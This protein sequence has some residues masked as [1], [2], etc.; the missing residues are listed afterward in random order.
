MILYGIF[1]MQS[2]QEF[3]SSKITGY[4]S[5][6]INTKVSLKGIDISIFDHII[7]EKLYIE[8][9]RQDTL[10]YVDYLGVSID[11]LDIS[12]ELVEIGKIS[13]KKL[14]F[15]LK[16]DTAS[17]MNLQF[18]IDAFTDST[19]VD[20]T[21]TA[22]EFNWKIKCRKINI[23]N[24]SFSYF[25]SDTASHIS[26]MNYSDI[27]LSPIN[28]Y[29]SDFSF[30]KNIIKLKLDSLNLSDKSGL[31]LKKLN[32]EILYSDT[33]I[34]LSNG[35]LITPYSN[36]YFKN[37]SLHYASTDDFGDFLNKVKLNVQISDST[38]LSMKDGVFF[39][40][41][42]S[43]I[44][45]DIKLAANLF[46]VVNDLNTKLLRIKYG[47]NTKL[48]TRFTIKGLP[49]IDKT[50]FKVK[51]D[52]LTAS[53]DDLNSV[54]S[55]DN[56]AKPMV[57]LPASMKS[58]GKIYY[59]GIIKGRADNLKS[60]GRLITDIGNI[61]AML[62]LVQHKNGTMNING[63]L[64]GKQLAISDIIENKSIGK[65]DIK[66]TLNINITKSGDIEGVS[67]G[68]ANNIELLGYKYNHIDFKAILAKNEY[69]G[70]VKI[71][72]PS[73]KASLSGNYSTKDTVPIISFDTRIDKFHPYKLNLYSD[74]FFTAKLK[75]DGKIRG[76]DPDKLTANL[77]CR[78]GEIKNKQGSITNKDIKI[79]SKYTE[80]DSTHV[81]NLISD[82]ID[83]NLKGRLKLSTIA[84]SSQQYLYGIM[85]SLADT[86]VTLVENKDSLYAAL[87][88]DN[89]FDFKI[90][91][92]DLSG[93]DTM[94]MSGIKIAEGTGLSGKFNL[95]PN[96]LNLQGYCPSINVSGTKVEEIIINGANPDNKIDVYTSIGKIYL[97]ES[98]AINNSLI[99]SQ[100]IDDKAKLKLVWNS[101]LDSL[102]YNGDFS[103]TAFLEKRDTIAPLI[104]LQLDSSTF[105]FENNQ[106]I[107]RSNEMSID[108][109]RIDLG[110]ILARSSNQETIDVSGIISKS[111][112]DTLK[113]LLDKIKLSSFNN[114]VENLGI[115][116]HGTAYGKSEI[117]GVL[118]NLRVNSVDSIVGL[119]IDDYEVGDVRMRAKWDNKHSL[120]NLY[121]ETQL[122]STKNMI[123][124]GAYNVEKDSL[125]MN[126]TVTRFPFNTISPF[127]A[128]YMSKI[129]GKI[130][131]NL[132][133]EGSSKKPEI[134]AGLK[135]IRAGFKVNYLNTTYTF[136]DS[137]FI[138]K[139]MI[140]L[141]RMKINAGRN[142]FAWLSGKL[143]HKNFEN[144]KLNLSVEPHNFLFLDT[145]ETDSSLF[146][147][148]VYASGRINVNGDPDNMDVD[149]KLK[150]ERGTRFFLPLTSSSEVSEN[151]Y[152][153]FVKRDSSR[154]E[155][156]VEQKVDLSGININCQLQA[157]SDAEMQIIM[158]ETVGDVIKVR[159]MGNLDLQVNK[160]GDISL[161]GTYTVTKGD[162]LFT[163][164]NLVNK[165]FIVDRGSTIR[166]YGNPY[167]A[168]MN[169]TALYKIRKVPLYDLMQD[170]AFKERK[171][172]VECKLGMKGYLSN[173]RISFGLNVLDADEIV[174]SS[175]H[176]LDQNDLNQ[177]ILSLLLLG[178]FQ[179]L[180]GLRSDDA[181]SGSDA[182]SNNAI[183]MLSN[184]LTNWLSKISDDFDIGINY[185]K[186]GEMSSDEVEMAL[187]TQ[188][189]NDRVSINT[190]V[191][192]SGSGNT[193]VSETEK[194][195]ANKI[196]GD[197]EIEV[198]LNKKGSLRAKVFNRTN[199]RNAESS[200]KSLYTQGVGIFFRKEFRTVGE[201][202]TD[203][204]KTVTFQNVKKKKKLKKKKRSERRKNRKNRKNK[205][206]TQNKDIEKEERG[207]EL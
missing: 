75:M 195:S 180:P 172:N 34:D 108:T 69:K 6:K 70:N 144:I 184:Q 82:I 63:N 103:L 136:T 67:T 192:V 88:R 170:V 142:S 1:R 164:Q 196:V 129:R 143:A 21:E 162:Y 182:I 14:D 171:T 5:D 45:Q 32:S 155:V 111:Q 3:I 174:N 35:S 187:S 79:D 193:E 18:I 100:L 99:H 190:N 152:I 55:F 166:W 178:E 7:L 126:L 168:E 132:H 158:D 145:Q 24:S 27:K 40:P 205:S 107:I 66:D 86:S 125:D 65:F 140:K 91:I 106:W 104:K 130:S 44:T 37:L 87:D 120:L 77:N 163:L 138:D 97:S 198:K 188:L 134:N 177:Q 139:N 191:G 179:P 117:A 31:K 43:I 146:Y 127:V 10:L 92:K 12:D 118:G 173:P 133:I 109:G 161:Y 72:D 186:G 68:I 52:T 11:D 167:E 49:D 74:T 123:L 30:H 94:F 175:I 98:S 148:R 121:T 181:S 46:G 48:K 76:I 38:V 51:I 185:K 93:I 61:D 199:Q 42:L 157:T 101:F 200:D 36:I 113:L 112:Q 71:D 160:V 131:G 23:E 25:V 105:A 73:V 202:I 154:Q 189:F 135:F 147:G 78:I 64:R 53:I 59:R 81:I 16:F 110:H 156:V 22:S 128:S 176:R 201:L 4:L 116:L 60:Q 54:K 165:K 204:W 149:I 159:G 19:A 15:N 122:F 151:K 29:A 96:N 194:K 115:E 114:F 183:E 119:K 80:I 203:L 90:T 56:P 13:L 39:E 62:N 141:K 206:A 28:M 150:T 102:N 169:M 57:E 33:C 89:N 58:I 9:Q 8:D 26:G 47:N 20:T 153:T 84:Q 83:V 95:K 137:L 17:Q 50:V 124:K 85:P 41:R 197:V 207:E 2:V